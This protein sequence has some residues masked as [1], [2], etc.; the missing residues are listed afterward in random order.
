MT[1]KDA[2]KDAEVSLSWL[3]RRI[4]VSRPT[5][6]K[7]LDKPDE[8]KVKHVRRIAKYLHMTEREAL[9]NYFKQAESYE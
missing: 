5:L 7:Y 6:Y 4:G 1:L 9:I 2:L 8:F 3:S